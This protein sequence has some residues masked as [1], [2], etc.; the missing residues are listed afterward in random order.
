MSNALYTLCRVKTALIYTIENE[1]LPSIT[2][3]VGTGPSAVDVLLV[4]V[5][6]V[7]VASGFLA[8]RREIERRVAEEQARAP[9]SARHP[10]IAFLNVH[11][12]GEHPGIILIAFVRM[13]NVFGTV[14][15]ALPGT[16]HSAG[17]GGTARA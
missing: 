2:R 17:T 15:P 13:P 3:A 7:V 5:H 16:M 12:P 10:S 1:K 9:I 6:D 11:H 14:S 4:L 8:S